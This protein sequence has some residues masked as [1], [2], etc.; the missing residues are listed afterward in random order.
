MPRFNA[1]ASNKPLQTPTPLWCAT[2]LRYAPP[3]RCKQYSRID[4]HSQVSWAWNF[5][6]DGARFLRDEPVCWLDLLWK[7]CHNQHSRQFCEAGK[8]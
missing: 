2:G 1:A 8:V 7:S 4:A 5:W 6:G 3:L